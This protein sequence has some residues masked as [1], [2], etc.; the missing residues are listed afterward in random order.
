M[1]LLS[2]SRF[3]SGNQC[4]L[5]LWNDTHRRDLATPPDESLQ[6]IFEIGNQVGELAQLRWPGGVLVDGPYWEIDAAVARTEALM[7]DPAVPAIYE[8]AIVHE[9]A[10]TRVDVLARAPA[11]SWDLI[12]VKSSTKVKEPFDTDVA[13]QYWI[14]NG[15]GLTVRRAGVL[16][17][18]TGYLYPG[19]EYDVDRLFRFEDLTEDCHRRLN[20]IGDQVQEF[21]QVMNRAQ[22][23]EVAVGAHCHSPYECPYWDHCT[24]DVTFPERPIDMLPKLHKNRRSKL[25]GM[26][27]ESLDDVPADFPLTEIQARVREC[28]RSGESWVSPGLKPALEQLQWPVAYLDFEAAQFPLPRYPGT[29]PYETVPFQFSC[30]VQASPNAELFHHEYLNTDGSDPR[31]AIAHALLEAVGEEGSIVVYSSYEKQMIRALAGWFP[32]LGADLL[33]L[34]DRLFDLLPVIRDNYYHPDFRGSFSI[35]AVLPALIDDMAYDNMAI[36]DGMVAARTWKQATEGDPGF[37]SDA[38]ARDLRDYCCQDSLAMAR[39]VEKLT[40]VSH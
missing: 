22:P 10:L 27:V 24:R 23:P 11:G 17:L 35:K 33:R 4:P 20:E 8:A 13:L 7:A 18:N 21:R 19:G 9:G 37:L 1:S 2:K 3:I 16:L 28:T 29:R 26:G 31:E 14:L 25:E 5:K 34:E 6:A 30:H 40:L 36:S 12:E 32:H 39:V 15:A 38:A